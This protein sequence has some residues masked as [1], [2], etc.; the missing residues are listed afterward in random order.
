MAA[1]PGPDAVRQPSP[2]H[3]AGRG[4][5]GIAAVA[6]VLALAA[7]VVGGGIGGVVGYNIADGGATGTSALDA[8]KPPA[9]QASS[10]PAGSAEQVAAKVLPSVVQLQVEGR[11]TAGEGSGI[12]LSGDGLI[13]TNNHVVEAAANGGSMIAV[14][15]DGRRASAAIVGRDPSS[16]LAIVRAEGVSGLTAAELGRS[17]DLAVG[18]QVV[19]IGSPLGL[20]GTVTT[21]IISALNRPVRAGGQAS[22]Q[23]TVLD[24]IQTDA[25]INPGNS[26]GPLVDDQGRVIGINSAIATVSTGSDGQGGSIGLGFAIPIDQARRIADEL[27]R[28]GKATQAVLGV[29]VSAGQGQK[30]TLG[31]TVAKVEPGSA[32]ERAGI[33][34]GEVITKI[35]DRP[36]EDSDELVAAVRSHAPGD[37]IKI[38]V[39]DGTDQRTVDATLGSR[40]IEAGG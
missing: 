9:R 20:S 4:R 33:K 19:A 8:A 24:A 40:T 2:G 29:S 22:D 35:D 1:P 31:A 13:L 36:I 28:N 25:A 6:T 18:Q 32:A 3:P 37:N 39:G 15:S 10:A 38:E 26:G 34:V 16:D 7:G 17:D 5:T 30:A 12:V 11:T 23:T 14:F 21:G 27:T